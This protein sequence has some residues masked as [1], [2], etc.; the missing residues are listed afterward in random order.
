MKVLFD[1]QIFTMQKYGG[2]SQYFSELHKRLPDSDIAISYSRNGYIDY[3]VTELPKQ[4]YLGMAG[5]YLIDYINQQN[6]TRRLSEDFDI[7]HPTYYNPYF[8]KRLHGKPYVLTVFDMA[9]ERYPEMFGDAAMVIR[10]K[11][12]LVENATRLVAISQSTKDDMLLEYDIDPD[13]ITVIHLATSLTQVISKN[14]GFPEK[15]IL[16]VG[17]REARYKGFQDFLITMAQMME[18][19][20]NLWVICAGGGSFTGKEIMQIPPKLLPRVHQ[21]TFESDRELACLY[22]HAEAFVFPSWIEG[23][24]I[25]QLEAMTCGCPMACSDIPVFHE[26]ARDSAEYFEAGNT[27]SMR[28]AIIRARKNKL[29][30]KERAREFSWDKMAKQTIE[31]YERCL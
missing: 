2:I 16:F 21:V 31:V 15:Y 24:G 1:H 10:N 30:G 11:K 22:Q 12:Q 25:P 7:F 4:K 23:F 9:H 28:E 6:T 18:E 8:L 20:K 14:S 26:I 27:G 5:F 19:D 3:P 17:S 13:L 29:M